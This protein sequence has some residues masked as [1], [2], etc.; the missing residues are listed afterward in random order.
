MSHLKILAIFYAL[1]IFACKDIKEIKKSN[2]DASIS[3]D[4]LVGNWKRSNNDYGKQTYENWNKSNDSIYLGLGFTMQDTDTI[5]LE[6][7]K[8]MFRDSFWIYSVTAKGET[9]STDF[10]LT[11]KT[12]NSFVC[13][14]PNNEFPKMITYNI[15]GDSLFAIISGG[16]PDVE[17][18]FGK[19]R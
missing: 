18:K 5:W 1:I 3:F 8:L 11:S 6:N 2:A 7:V 17:F 16:G 19:E 9:I 12:N 4:W 15:Q 10:V 14:N 13:E